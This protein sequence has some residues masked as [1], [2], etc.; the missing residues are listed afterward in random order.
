[1]DVGTLCLRTYLAF[2]VLLNVSNGLPEDILETGQEKY[3]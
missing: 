2:L 3:M 1:M